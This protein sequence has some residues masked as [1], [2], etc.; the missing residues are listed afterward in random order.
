MPTSKRLHP[1]VINRAS[2]QGVYNRRAAPVQG[3]VTKAILKYNCMCKELRGNTTSES[4]IGNG[5]DKVERI[6]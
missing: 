1:F 4:T 6:D 3:S 2:A 5:E